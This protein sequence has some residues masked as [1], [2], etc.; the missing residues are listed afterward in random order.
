MN[1]KRVMISTALGVLAGIICAHGSAGSVPGLTI[2]ILAA[3][4][5]DRVLLGFVV[6]IAD[7]ISLHPILRGA[8]I[9][10]IVSLEI[11]IPSGT[12]GGAILLGAGM[13]YGAIIDLVA[14]RLT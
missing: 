1:F 4:F 7:G 12:T 8:I 13:L 2:P 9:G 3:I 6:G 10:A 11:A 5:Y 14:T